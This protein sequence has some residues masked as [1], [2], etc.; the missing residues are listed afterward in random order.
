MCQNE[1]VNFLAFYREG[2]I[3]R[4]LHGTEW[5]YREAGHTSLAE[6]CERLTDACR[7]ALGHDRVQIITEKEVSFEIYS[8]STENIITKCKIS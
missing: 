5:V 4:E 8:P 3:F 6:A 2:T 7:C 1:L